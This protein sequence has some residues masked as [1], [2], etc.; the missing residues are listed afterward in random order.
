MP[1]EQKVPEKV[2]ESWLVALQ[3]LVAV[4]SPLTKRL[5]DRLVARDEFT[6]AQRIRLD[7]LKPW[8]EGIE[9]TRL[10]ADV[11]P[12]EIPFGIMG[13]KCAD[14]QQ[15]SRNI[16]D[17]VQTIA[18]SSHVLRRTNVRLAG[19]ANLVE[20]FERIRRL[21]PDGNAISG[22]SGTL[23][24]VEVNR[25]A[26][27]YDPIPP[28]TWTLVFGW[29]MKQP[30]GAPSPFPLNPNILPIFLS[31]HLSRSDILTPAAI[32]YLKKYG[33][34][35]CRD[36]STVRILTKA[37]VPAYFSG[38]V[39]T[40]IGSLFPS[41]SLTGEKPVALVDAK[42]SDNKDNAVQ[43]TNLDNKLRNIDLPSG[44]E[45]AFDRLQRYQ[46]E[47]SGVV[48]SRLLTY[49][50]ARAMGV[51]VEWRPEDPNDRRFDGLV[52]PTA[53]SA[54]EMLA[55]ISRLVS[56]VVDALLAR[57]DKE[58]VYKAYRRI[59]QAEVEASTAR[60]NAEQ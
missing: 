58:S 22:P 30:F 44:L 13:Y 9:K 19:D 8:A 23:R 4:S 14:Y 27:H 41:P 3:N 36:W 46:S 11:P 15:A 26:S 33:P 55:R 48:T 53:E 38:C 1:A 31:F 47:F 52:G 18:M 28:D 32:E 2:A 54:D 51:P 42:G 6:A 29:F 7:R 39:T 50:P 5:F 12:G 10:V 21:I 43:L 20:L 25:D 59:A 57:G 24:L 37:G 34:V 49:L 40:T 16:G 56:A 17:W 45:D 60:I 35:G